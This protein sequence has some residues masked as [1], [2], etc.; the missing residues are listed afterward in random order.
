MLYCTALF[1]KK[2][3]DLRVTCHYQILKPSHTHVHSDVSVDEAQ[4]VFD[5]FKAVEGTSSWQTF[6]ASGSSNE[7]EVGRWVYKQAM[8]HALR[9]WLTS[10]IIVIIPGLAKQKGAAMQAAVKELSSILTD[11]VAL[12]VTPEGAQSQIQEFMSQVGR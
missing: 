11:A 7:T 1:E 12:A 9:H 4:T 6:V 8:D 10:I 5:N 2:E 3:R